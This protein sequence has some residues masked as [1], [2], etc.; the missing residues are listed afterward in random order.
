MKIDTIKHLK[1]HRLKVGFSNG[2][3]KDIDLGNFIKSS[4]HPLIKKYADVE[5][6]KK[7]YLD[8]TGTPCWGKNEFDISPQS[9]INGDFDIN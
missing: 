9:I 2:T 7:V 5:L 3:S 4:S 1:N 8:E 6:F